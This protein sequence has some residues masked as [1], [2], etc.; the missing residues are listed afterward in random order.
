MTIIQ[1]NEI[2]PMGGYGS[3]GTNKLES[4][5][6]FG[7]LVGDFTS[8]GNDFYILIRASNYHYRGLGLLSYLKIGPRKLIRSN[9]EQFKLRSFS[10]LGIMLI[11]CPPR[12]FS[13]E[14][15]TKGVFGLA[16]LFNYS[17]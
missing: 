1:G 10:I 13:P 7:K 8:N 9:F 17:I 2:F 11:S 12:N 3:I 14:K 15:K 6:Q 16:F 4:I 5:S